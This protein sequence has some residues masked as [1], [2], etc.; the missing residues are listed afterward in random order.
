MISA[1]VTN[2]LLHPTN[3]NVFDNVGLI[4][5]EDILDPSI[6]GR[7]KPLFTFIKNYPLE[8]QIKHIK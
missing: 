8:K 7:A 4:E 2:I 5:W 3:I 1:R 6:V